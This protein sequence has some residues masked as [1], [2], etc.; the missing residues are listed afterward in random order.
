MHRKYNY[1][2][3]ERKKNIP[4]Q[5]QRGK[6]FSAPVLCGET[7]PALFRKNKC[8]KNFFAQKTLGNIKI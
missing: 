7:F 2:P 3:F 6:I 4:G 5:N 1:P 8:V